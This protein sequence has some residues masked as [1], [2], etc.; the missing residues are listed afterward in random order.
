MIELSDV[1]LCHACRDN[2][3]CRGIP[4]RQL[5]EKRLCASWSDILNFNRMA[6]AR[7]LKFTGKEGE[8]QRL[9]LLCSDPR[10]NQNP[11]AIWNDR[12]RIELEVG[13][14]LTCVG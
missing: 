12:L 8:H 1:R 9:K 2:L 10:E 13:I 3:T 11:V 7:R 4:D 14:C 5:L 6:K